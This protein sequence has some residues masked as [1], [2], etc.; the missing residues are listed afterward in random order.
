M[1]TDNVKLSA[2]VRLG[3]IL[4]GIVQFSSLVDVLLEPERTL[5]YV[6][7]AVFD[8]EVMSDDRRLELIII[9]TL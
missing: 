4:Y 9:L 2:F 1:M 6:Y 5:K 7:G 8:G 3:S